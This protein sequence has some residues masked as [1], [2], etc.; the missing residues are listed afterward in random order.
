MEFRLE[1]SAVADLNLI[2]TGFIHI[3]LTD[4]PPY[5]RPDGP[6]HTGDARV[7]KRPLRTGMGVLGPD[8][9]LD[10]R[11]PP[12]GLQAAGDP[13]RQTLGSGGVLIPA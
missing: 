8:R 12:W 3:V 5:E 10:E 11:P 13:N 9:P 6:G 4:R 2:L 7:F 1:L